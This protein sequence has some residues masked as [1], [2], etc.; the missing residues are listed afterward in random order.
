MGPHGALSGHPHG[1]QRH[2]K[3]LS[4]H[5]VSAYMYSQYDFT[6]LLT[7][8]VQYGMVVLLTVF[9][10]VS[11]AAGCL[12]ICAVYQY[13]KGML[14]G[15]WVMMAVCLVGFAVTA[16]VG[17]SLPLTF[18]SEGCLSN[19]YPGIGYI[20]NQTT[21]AINRFCKESPLNCTCYLKPNTSVYE[22][23][24]PNSIANSTNNYTY[25]ISVLEC[26]GWMVGFYDNELAAYENVLN[27]AGWCSKHPY[28]L[29]SDINRG[30]N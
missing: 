14:T 5:A 24:S 23:L 15:F 18:Y 4:Y 17:L 12:G 9:S 26:G 11:L 2:H 6:Y 25:P 20:N 19:S 21:L 10:C 30:T 8:N 1:P 16:A 13:S 28:Y 3:Y 7:T 29:F 27:C 22:S